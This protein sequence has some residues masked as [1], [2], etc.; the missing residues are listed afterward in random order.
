MSL[1]TLQWLTGRKT[2]RVT[3]PALTEKETQFYTMCIHNLCLQPYCNCIMQLKSKF[4]LF[5]NNKDSIQFLNRTC[6]CFHRDIFYIRVSKSL[7][8]VAEHSWGLIQK[9]SLSFCLVSERRD[10]EQCVAWNFT[11]VNCQC[12]LFH[13]VY[14]AQCA[15]AC[16][17][18]NSCVHTKHPKHR[19]PSY[20]LDT[21][22]KMYH[23]LV[24]PLKMECGQQEGVQLVRQTPTQ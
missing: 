3:Y 7:M 13:S 12:R 4:L 6:I 1:Y 5:I 8:A 10:L 11:T 9:S 24:Q 17:I 20:C 21:C 14:T 18:N 15:A 19:Q 2:P 22:M 23:T 16:I